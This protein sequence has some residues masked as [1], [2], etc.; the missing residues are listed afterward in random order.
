VP[1]LAT[2]YEMLAQIR[3]SVAN[4]SRLNRSSTDWMLVFRLEVGDKFHGGHGSQA[5][6]AKQSSS[7]IGSAEVMSR[8]TAQK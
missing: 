7:E 5:V 4:I 1:A 2:I 8:K 3:P 6:I